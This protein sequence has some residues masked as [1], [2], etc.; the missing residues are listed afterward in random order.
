M[1]TNKQARSAGCE[2]LADEEVTIG[3]TAHT[4]TPGR[5]ETDKE[6]I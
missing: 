5:L 1:T 4:P 3:M 6:N 2:R